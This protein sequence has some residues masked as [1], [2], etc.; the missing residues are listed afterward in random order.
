[1]RFA[2]A[3]VTVWW[4]GTGPPDR[5]FT[6]QLWDAN[7]DIY[8]EILR[9]PF[10][11]GMTDGSLPHETFARYLLQDA[12]YLRE[13]AA[14]LRVIATKA[15]K[16]EWAALLERHAQESL[17]EEVGLQHTILAEYGVSAG[18]QARAEP[19]PDALAYTSFIVATAY[20]GS[21]GEAMSAVLPCY[22]I[23][24]ELGRDLKTR[25]SPDASYRLWIDSYAAP[26]YSRSVDE[27]LEIVNEVAMKADDAERRR[28]MDLYRQGSRYE[29]MFW[30]AAFRPRAWPPQAN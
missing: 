12:F 10:I 17:D 16:K 19:P 14:A 4:L 9:H 8:Q 15:P 18:A 30:D 22:W 24:R 13:F 5:A 26:G 6:D 21:F 11:G 2:L 29:W 25:Q 3:L 1:M 20:R 27:V 28:M 23:Y 7:R